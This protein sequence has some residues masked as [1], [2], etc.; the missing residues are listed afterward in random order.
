MAE[1]IREK[2]I[3]ETKEE[4]PYSAAVT[5]ESFE[6]ERPRIVRI[7]ATIHVERDT[8]KG[9][10]IGKGGERLKTIGTRAR[11]DIEHL[12]ESSGVPRPRGARDGEV[13]REQPRDGGARLR[14]ATAGDAARDAARYL[15]VRR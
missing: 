3:L 12:L 6:D 8:Q 7:L 15:R 1:F 5:V 14:R 4:L 2:V 11:K 9:I 13:E 10:V